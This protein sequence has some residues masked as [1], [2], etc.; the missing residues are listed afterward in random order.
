[1]RRLGVFLLLAF[2]GLP[3]LPAGA[4]EY[5]LPEATI[6]IRVEP[7]GAITVT[8]HIT[9][10][11]DGAFSGGF[12]EI[13]LAAG[14]RIREVSVSE[15]SAIYQDGAC[16]D[17]GCSAP[18]GTF[19]VR[20]LGGRTRVVW[21]YAAQGERR[22]FEIRY[23]IEGLA[24]IYDDYVDVYLQV[25][26]SE[27]SV[28]LDQLTASMAIPSGAEEGE[29]Y[30]WGH[31]A[32]VDGETSLGEG[33]VS[34]SLEAYGIP[35]SQFVEFR[36]AF[37]RRLLLGSG[38]GTVLPGEGLAFVLEEEERLA[39]VAAEEAARV[40]GAVGWGAA[41]MFIPALAAAAFIYLNFGR[42]PRVDYDREY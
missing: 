11:F 42:E 36:V 6:D 1:M 41:A 33:G 17:R 19:G 8:E 3:A 9:Y 13:P 26:G 12:R 4:R 10:E 20:D 29:V 38:G 32:R 31:P 24:K 27:W 35:P 22:T 23:T 18:A 2:L 34:P 15:G 30:V 39:N 40:R 14:E 21:H 7:D 37:P 28:G 16:T 25:W 5:S